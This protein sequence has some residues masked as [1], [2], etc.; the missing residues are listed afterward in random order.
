[1]VTT[2]VEVAVVPEAAD[3]AAVVTVA[4]ESV[5]GRV[6]RPFPSALV[7]GMRPKSSCY[8]FGS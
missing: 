6:S 7:S 1:M 2:W 5:A 3:V 4:V 8:C